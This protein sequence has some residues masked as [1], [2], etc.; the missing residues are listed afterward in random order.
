[1]ISAQICVAVG[2]SKNM[3]PGPAPNEPKE[4]KAA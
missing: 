4:T 2:E 1:M 3:K